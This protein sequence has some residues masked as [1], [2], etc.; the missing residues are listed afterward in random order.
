MRR[1]ALLCWAALVA[2]SEGTDALGTH[3][4]R[5]VETRVMTGRMGGMERAGVDNVAVDVTDQLAAL[6]MDAACEQNSPVPMGHTAFFGGFG[7][8]GRGEEGSGVKR[9][10]TVPV[11]HTP[12]S[13]GVAGADLLAVQGAETQDTPRAAW[14]PGAGSVLQCVVTLISGAV[15]WSSAHEGHPGPLSGP[16]RFRGRRVLALADLQGRIALLG[17]QDFPDGQPLLASWRLHIVS[18]GEGRLQVYMQSARSR[19]FLCSDDAGVLRTSGC[20]ARECLWELPIA[21][22]RPLQGFPCKVR[23]VENERY[24]S[25]NGSVPRTSSDRKLACELSFNSILVAHS[26][27]EMWGWNASKQHCVQGGVQGSLQNGV[28]CCPWRME[29]AVN[30]SISRSLLLLY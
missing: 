13:W 29:D 8:R 16:R 28:A 26:P 10:S 9:A 24:L 18:A 20:R 19:R 15:D 23:S 21:A 25:V 1:L 7:N 11:G 6:R 2:G 3:V 12:F 17:H 14:P 4:V 27:P 5:T 30:T 22:L